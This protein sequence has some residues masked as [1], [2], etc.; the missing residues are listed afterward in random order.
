[1]ITNTQ[2]GSFLSHLQNEIELQGV[3]TEAR[4]TIG[5]KYKDLQA[6]F[7]DLDGIKKYL[8]YLEKNRVITLAYILRPKT[9]VIKKS[10]DGHYFETRPNSEIISRDAF[11]KVTRYTQINYYPEDV[12]VFKYDKKKIIDT[13]IRKRQE[14]KKG[15]A[16][17]FVYRI[18]C[19]EHRPNTNKFIV[20]INENYQSPFEIALGKYWSRMHELAKKQQVAQNKGFFDYFNSNSNNPLYRKLRY[21]KTQILKY[22]G[23]ALIVPNIK[24]GL[25]NNKAFAQRKNKAA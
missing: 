6:A 23:A 4:G 7:E 11:Y 5:I 19:V 2:L 21:K 17:E 10:D 20:I 9:K 8:G 15:R 18:E 1:M 16:G 13:P 12:F 22:D 24:I 3:S 25:I 14:N